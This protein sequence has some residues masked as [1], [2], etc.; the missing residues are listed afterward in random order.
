M[1]HLKDSTKVN[2]FGELPNHLSNPGGGLGVMSTVD[3]NN[4]LLFGLRIK[5]SQSSSVMV[6]Y[7][8]LLTL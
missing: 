5:F 2:W 4:V 1:L 6:L 7:L 3:S 8:N